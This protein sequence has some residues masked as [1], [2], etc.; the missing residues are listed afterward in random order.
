MLSQENATVV[1]RF[2]EEAL[3]QQNTDLVREICS[4]YFVHRTAPAS[5]GSGLEGWVKVVK[6]IFTAFPDVHYAVEDLVAAEDRVAVRWTVTGTHRGEYEGVAPTGKQVTLAGM[7]LCRME[8]QQIH[9]MWN[10]W[11]GL[12]FMQQIGVALSPG[13]ATR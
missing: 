1:R 13:P 8:N 6:E 3:N 9:E 11:D 2:Y 5:Q 10:V 4:D 12:S 7:S